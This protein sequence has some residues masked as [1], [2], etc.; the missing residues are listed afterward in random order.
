ILWPN[1]TIKS[2]LA[3]LSDNM[4]L[5]RTNKNKFY[6][7]ATIYLGKGKTGK[8][9]CNKLQN[10]ITKYISESANKTGK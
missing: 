10:L 7:R 8:Q 4:F 6:I 9:V 2:L 5:Y 1:P 3:Y